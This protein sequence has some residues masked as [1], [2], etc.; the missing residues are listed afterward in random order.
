MNSLHRQSENG[1]TLIELMVVIAII[2]ILA[3]IAIPQF[4]AYRTRTYVAALKSDA[5]SLANAQ[6]AYFVENRAYAT[7]AGS[8]RSGNY[9]AGN[10]S[11]DT[12]IVNWRANATAFSFRLKNSSHAEVITVLYNSAS[13]GIK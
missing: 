4:A 12:T 9:G 7:T 2:G 1:F 8:I 10:L 11:S 3:A 13:G 6:E 5:H